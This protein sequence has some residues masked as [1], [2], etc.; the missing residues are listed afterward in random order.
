MYK[1]FWYTE[2]EFGP[3]THDEWMTP[4]FSEAIQLFNNK[5]VDNFKAS[6]L[7]HMEKSHWITHRHSEWE[8]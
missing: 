6:I 7:V 1:I 4:N 3:I 8:K 2:G 5:V